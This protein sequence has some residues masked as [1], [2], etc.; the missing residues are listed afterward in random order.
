M[1]TVTL[2]IPQLAL[3]VA[4]RAMGA[5]GVALLLGDRLDR[6]QRRAVGA[7]LAAVGALTTLPLVAEVVSAAR[8]S[9]RDTL[10]QAPGRSP[11][12][13]AE[14]PGHTPQVAANR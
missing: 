6:D 1:R 7:T 5:A 14:R 12:E 9:R 3:L 11:L 4:T 8:A 13:D 2:S 10:D